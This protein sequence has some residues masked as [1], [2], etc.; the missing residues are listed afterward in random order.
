MPLVITSVK[1]DNLF[2]A[3][4]DKMADK[5]ARVIAKPIRIF[6]GFKLANNLFIEPTKSFDFSLLAC[7]GLGIF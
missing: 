5:K 1:L 3:V 6:H 2:G 4:S 7:I